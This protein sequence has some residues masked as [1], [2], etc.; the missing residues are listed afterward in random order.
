MPTILELTYEGNY[1]GRAPGNNELYT[2]AGKVYLYNPKAD[3][4]WEI[5]GTFFFSM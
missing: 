3:L 4:S 2:Y 1:V 5:D